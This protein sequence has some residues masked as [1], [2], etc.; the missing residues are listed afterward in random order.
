MASFTID[1]CEVQPTQLVVSLKKHRELSRRFETNGVLIGEPLPVKRIGNDIF[2]TDGHT[3]ALLL[4]QNGI[5]SI[6]VVHDTDDLDWIMY[7]RCM[8]WCRD[9]GIRT[10]ADLENRMVDEPAFTEQWIHR[11]ETYRKQL[12]RNPVAD[13]IIECIDDRDL[14]SQ[15]CSEILNSLPKWFGIEAAIRHYV[16]K[17]RDLGFVAV[18]LYG[19]FIGFC[20]IKINYTINAD[21]YVLSIFEAFHGKG[22]GKL[23]MDFIERYCRNLKIPYMTVKTLSD[24]HPDENYRRTRKFYESCGFRAF[25]EFPELWG[26]DNPCL[27]MIKEVRSGRRTQFERGCHGIGT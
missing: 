4:W 11:C 14:K 25:E 2:F 12:K 1:L 13:V 8:Q 21:L 24:A 19:K 23:M 20:A 5:R 18:R 7:L 3:R 15:I 10:I 16:E 22:I 26:A 17:V 6:E 27:Y 9:A